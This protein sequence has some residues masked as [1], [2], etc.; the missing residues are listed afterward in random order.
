MNRD[1][2]RDLDNWLTTPPDDGEMVEC[3]DCDGTGEVLATDILGHGYPD[4]LGLENA[5]C[6]FC[7]G[8]GEVSEG[9]VKMRD[10][11]RAEAERAEEWRGD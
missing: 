3:S 8:E 11:D 9:A 2:K 1:W 10:Y 5:D 7:E 6:P 4:P